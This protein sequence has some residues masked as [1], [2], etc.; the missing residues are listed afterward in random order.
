MN[1]ELMINIRRK[2]DP[3][4]IFIDVC[5]G[6]FFSMNGPPYKVSFSDIDFDLPS[7]PVF[8]EHTLDSN[9][10]IW[11]L[12]NIPAQTTFQMTVVDAGQFQSTI[13]SFGRLIVRPT[14]IP[15]HH[16]NQSTPDYM[17]FIIFIAGI[18]GYMVFGSRRRNK[19]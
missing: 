2:Q 12:T 13:T 10:T 9:V 18:I 5:V 17:P 16:S 7:R 1:D 14:P 6:S 11:E 8:Y 4:D 3:I 19:T 15:N